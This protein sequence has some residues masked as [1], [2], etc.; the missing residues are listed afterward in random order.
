[1]ANFTATIY[2]N[3]TDVKTAVDAIDNTATIHVLSFVD[4]GKTKYMVIA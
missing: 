3:P 1:M 2:T 4:D